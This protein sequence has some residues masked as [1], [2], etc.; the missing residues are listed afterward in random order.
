MS[1]AFIYIV[2]CAECVLIVNGAREAVVVNET[3]HHLQL[4][5]GL[6][7]VAIVTQGRQ[8]VS[9]RCCF[10]QTPIGHPENVSMSLK[11]QFWISDPCLV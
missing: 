3:A 9:A 5:K 1:N 10:Q 2:G 11:Q 7:M 6:L 4:T 8:E